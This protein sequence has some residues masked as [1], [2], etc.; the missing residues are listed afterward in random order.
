MVICTPK[1]SRENTPTKPPA[2][3]CPSH[4]NSSGS[5][6][7]GSSLSAALLCL[8]LLPFSSQQGVH[9]QPVQKLWFADNCTGKSLGCLFGQLLAEVNNAWLLHQPADTHSTEQ[10][11]QTSSS[12]PSSSIPGLESLPEQTAVGTPY[13]CL[14]WSHHGVFAHPSCTEMPRGS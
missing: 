1:P 11:A 8:K 10:P 7:F 13:S 5:S 2:F 3:L 4:T 14:S 9:V 12:E 6:G